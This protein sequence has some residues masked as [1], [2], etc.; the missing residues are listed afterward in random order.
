M[1][2][3]WSEAMD[4]TP[5]ADVLDGAALV[6]LDPKLPIWERFF[7]VAPLVLIG[8]REENG[9]FDQAPKHMVTPLGWMNYFGF[10]CTPRH[11]TYQNIRREGAFTVSYPRPTQIVL[12][13][14]A[15][16]PR[17]DDDVKPALALLPTRPAR[18]IDGVF[19]R[20]GYLFLECMLDRIVDDFG[21]NSLIAG[22]I[23]AAEVAEDALRLSDGD[24]AEVL[25]TAPLLA[26]VAP[27]R[28]AEIRYGHAFPFPMGFAR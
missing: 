28:Y 6:S 11:R 17:D 22:R 16:A 1:T 9:T 26:Y 18:L 13:S 21:E 27:G 15:A 10:V 3:K 4:T 20:D 23:V 14:L 25:R 8:T 2:N 12:T 7:T 19:V 24:D 5:T